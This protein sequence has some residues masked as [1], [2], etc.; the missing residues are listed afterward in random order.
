MI[1]SFAFSFEHNLISSQQLLVCETFTKHI[2][3]LGFDFF[4]NVSFFSSISEKIYR[5]TAF[6]L[7]LNF[8]SVYQQKCKRQ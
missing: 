1:V 6:Y 7:T 4:V 5:R 2:S 3:R 8:F